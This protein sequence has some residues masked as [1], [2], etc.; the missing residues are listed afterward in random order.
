[1]FFSDGTPKGISWSIKTGEDVVEQHRDQAEMYL[2]KVNPE[3][4][5]YIALHVGMFWSVGMFIIKNGDEVIVNLDSKSMYEH[6]SQNFS[7]SDEFIETRTGFIKQ[8][9]AQRD[10]KISYRQIKPEE[11][12]SSKM[13]KK[14]IG[15]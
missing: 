5:R 3:Q 13:L 9:I 2:D 11:N 14:R 1:M 12:I 10:L 6:L 15:T 7:N 4:A 8:L